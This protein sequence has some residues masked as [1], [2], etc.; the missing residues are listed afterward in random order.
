MYFDAIIIG[1]GFSGLYQLHQCRDQIGL[2]TL[3]IEEGKEVGGTWYW[4][5]YPGS[6]CDTE[7]HI[8]CYT[9]SKEIYQ[10][11][12]WK[13]RY[14]KQKEILSYLKYVEKKLSL[15][16]DIIFNNRVNSA[17]YL[18]EKNL[19]RVK[20]NKNKTF[21][22]K[23]L[24]SAV[25][26]LS[27]TNVPNIRGLKNFKGGWYHTGR[28]PNKKIS[29]KNQKV[30]QI[31][32]GSSGIQIAP[33]LAKSVKS[34]TVFQRTPNYSVPARNKK[35][36]KTFI[37]NTID[38]YNHIKNLLKKTPGGHAFHFSKKSIFEFTESKRLKILEKAWLNGGLSFR[39][40]FSDITKKIS[41][42]K[43]V[44][45]YI[46][47]KIK[48]IVKDKNIAKILT[49]FGHPFTTKRPTLN[50]NYFETFNRKNVQLV[51]LKTNPIIKITKKGIKTKNEELKFD[52]IIFATGYDALTGP[53]LSLNL[54]G[55]KNIK[56]KK[57]WKNG[58]K[59]FL[60]I[61]IP[62]FPNFFIISGPGSPSVLTNVPAQIEQHVEWISKFIK[63]LEKVECR[64]VEPGR[65]ETE[66][67]VNEINRLANKSLFMKAKNS[68]YKGDNI[69]GKPKK[70]IPY[71]A[72][73]PQYREICNKVQKKMYKGFNMS[74][75]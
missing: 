67:W 5:K 75:K 45:N 57:Y 47:D 17:F 43:I 33:V 34:L 41:A 4:N 10:N 35:L 55:R 61:M 3:V 68:W 69:P 50:T 29:F 65:K 63:Y 31:G 60:G 52:K 9:F 74:L 19:W 51:D 53:I 22:C 48:R 8:Y 13:E 18:D 39:A 38:K 70:F 16:R 21:Y 44:S 30:A 26:S 2:K 72:G 54:T 42:N 25:G 23:Y 15:K 27:T 36:T 32:T 49:D 24:I 59:T 62:N 64:T 56:L 6:R 71:P 58:P 11:W 28:W 12:K 1:A 7:S 73:L 14:P 37:K 40:C 20:T 66:N 46:R